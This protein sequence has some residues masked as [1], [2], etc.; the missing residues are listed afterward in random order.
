MTTSLSRIGDIIQF[1]EFHQGLL[2]AML[3]EDIPE[4]VSIEKAQELTARVKEKAN[5]GMQY[6]ML[7]NGFLKNI[8]ELLGTTADA[9]SGQTLH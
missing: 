9:A 7:L 3:G 4:V 2:K 8:E 5:S 1:D 6:G